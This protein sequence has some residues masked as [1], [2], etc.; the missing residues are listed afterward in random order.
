MM[1][2]THR[3][4]KAWLA[5]LAIPAA[6]ILLSLGAEAGA[7][8]IPVHVTGAGWT[9][10]GA[11]L[12]SSDTVDLNYGGN[13]FQG[14]RGHINALAEISKNW[15]GS[16]GIGVRTVQKGISGREVAS[17]DPGSAARLQVGV[18][19]YISQ[20]RFTY[21]YGDES[22]SP[23]GMT[24][25]FFPFNYNPQVKNLGLYLLRGT[26]Y[27]G[28][29]FSGF[30]LDETIGVANLLGLNL[31]STLG[32]FSNDILLS[33]E[34]KIRPLFDYSLAYIGK[35]R[36]NSAF[37][38]GAG[39]NFYRLI[40]INGDLTTPRD[41]NLVAEDGS[42]IP[43][44]KY[45]RRHYYLDSTGPGQVDTVRFTL[46]GVKAGAF[47]TLDLKILT[48]QGA[49]GSEDLKLYGE[50]AV[51]GVKDYTGIYEDIAQR[52]PVMV[53]FNLP[54]FN[55]LDHLSLEVEYYKSPYRND[56]YKLEN[57]Y[58]PIPMSNLNLGRK[59]VTDPVTGQKVFSSGGRTFPIEDPYDAENMHKD[60]LKWSLHGAKTIKG[61][62]RL[63]AQAANDHF[64]PGG[65]FFVDKYESAFTT[66]KDWYFMT[67]LSY[68]F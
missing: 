49:M 25:G 51:I 12:N 32:H 67:K 66:L 38:I 14:V 9:Q 3:L 18:E 56:Y 33:S 40:P 39:V 61:H 27:P 24:F 2:T 63:S 36:P 54:M 34:T 43:V 22:T 31:H 65:A 50:M 1:R 11:I 26:V 45:D 53:G 30:E 55:L 23:F 15:E 8:G 13:W 19:P 29:L 68:F 48:G 47:A 57:Y 7:Q 21:T 62:I 20:A 37:E 35:Y 16:I 4:G 44:S 52:I 17:G 41:P 28:F 64:R 59:V 10:A 60:D 42:L 5:K 6:A 46:K 58:S